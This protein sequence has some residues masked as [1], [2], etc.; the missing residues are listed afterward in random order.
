MAFIENVTA[1]ISDV[2]AKILVAVIVLLVGFIVGRI[3]GRLLE[4]FLHEIELNV[5]VRK[6]LRKRIAAEQ[7]LGTL[8]AYSIYLVTILL[9]LSQLGLTRIVL[10]VLATGVIVLVLL[11][12]LLGIRDFIP[13]VLAGFSIHR[14]GLVRKG[15]TVRVAR[16]RGKVLHVGLVDTKI[17]TN[18][19]DVLLIPNSVLKN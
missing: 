13:N 2:L 9:A 19:G 16:A 7:L 18:T 17:K 4:K 10:Y 14:R 12:V 5:L 11:S 3:V 8:V 15:K 1:A 6:M